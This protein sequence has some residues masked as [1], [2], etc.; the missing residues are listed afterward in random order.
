MI[1]LIKIYSFSSI[2]LFKFYPFQIFVR[3]LLLSAQIQI[4]KTNTYVLLVFIAIQM[5]FLN[6]IDSF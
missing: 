6:I 3:P 2:N 5:Y 4:F 1:G